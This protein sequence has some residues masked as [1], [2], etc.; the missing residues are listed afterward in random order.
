MF[1][2]LLKWTLCLLGLI[3]TSTG[4]PEDAPGDFGGESGSG[5][6][7]TGKI[8]PAELNDCGKERIRS[9]CFLGSLPATVHRVPNRPY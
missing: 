7:Q 2:W 9:V 4:S 1:R 6:L 3:T 5:M 8:T